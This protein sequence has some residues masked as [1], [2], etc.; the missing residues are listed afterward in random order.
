MAVGHLNIKRL[1][2]MTAYK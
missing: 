2:M 1:T